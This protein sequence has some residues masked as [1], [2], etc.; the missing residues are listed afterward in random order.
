MVEVGAG[1]LTWLR[2]VPACTCSSANDN[3]PNHLNVTPGDGELA[4]CV[5]LIRVSVSRFAH[6][7]CL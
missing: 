6:Q 7:G 2:A 5:N 1:C 4:V 3:E